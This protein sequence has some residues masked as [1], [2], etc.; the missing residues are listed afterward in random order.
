LGELVVRD[1][2]MESGP[3]EPLG[4]ERVDV[5]GRGSAARATQSGLLLG[6]ADL[7]AGTAVVGVGTRSE[8]LEQLFARH[9]PR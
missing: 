8:C 7:R 3:V 6:R 1:L 9:E 2:L 4:E 5:S